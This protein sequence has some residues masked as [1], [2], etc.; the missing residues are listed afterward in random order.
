MWLSWKSDPLIYIVSFLKQPTRPLRGCPAMSLWGFAHRAVET[1]APGDPTRWRRVAGTRDNR[2]NLNFPPPSAPP[3]PPKAPLP[4][5]QAPDT[6][7]WSL[8]NF[9]SNLFFKCSLVW[10]RVE[11]KKL[12]QIRRQVVHGELNELKSERAN[13]ER[14]KEGEKT[15]EGRGRALN[16]LFG[17]S[18]S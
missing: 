5:P 10:R 9:E 15:H 8:F 17:L 1:E 7:E 16:V 2:R 3:T 6:K 14:E 4:V 12:R 18:F 11:K 13:L